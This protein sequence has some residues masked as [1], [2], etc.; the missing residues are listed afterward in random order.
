MCLSFDLTACATRPRAT[1]TRMSFAV[2]VQMKGSGLL[3][4]PSTHGL[5]RVGS[6]PSSPVPHGHSCFRCYFKTVGRL[7]A[8]Y[9]HPSAGIVPD[10]LASRPVAN[11]I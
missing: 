5:R 2:A 6:C 7:A 8:R 4:A 10:R 11:L 3:W 1:L 9:W